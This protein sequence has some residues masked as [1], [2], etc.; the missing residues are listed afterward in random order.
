MHALVDAD[1]LRYEVGFASEVGWKNGDIPPWEYVQEMLEMRLY[2]IMRGAGATT[3]TLFLTEG[4][5]FR[6]DIATVKPYKGNR[7]AE[8]PWHYDNLTVY[9][10]DVLGATIVTHIEADDAMSII[11]VAQNEFCGKPVTIICTR[12]KDLK[13]VPGWHYQWEMGAQGEWGPELVKKEGDGLT[14]N[15]KRSSVV[16][17]GLPFFY[18]QVLQGDRA[19]N[20]PGLPGCGAVKTYELLEDLED[21]ASC[22]E[23]AYQDHYGDEWEER[24][25][26]Q[27]QLC[28]MTRRLHTD[29][30]PVL[31]EL[32]VEE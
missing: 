23:D 5:T 22:V 19:D 4:P 11:Q 8:K 14:L 32:G 16:G 24:L 7:K 17:T 12:D 27:G 25:L 21:P 13:Q 2:R 20:I 18:S 15:K 30:K 9:M 1:I 10:R 28:W 31:W 26:E 3:S 6:Y 29:G